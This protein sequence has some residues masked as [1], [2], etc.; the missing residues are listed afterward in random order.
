MFFCA[1]V[2]FLPKLREI[3]G[4]GVLPIMAYAGRLL[5]KGVTFFTL[6]VYERVGNSRVEVYE[7]EGKSVI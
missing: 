6:Q 3:P 5:P 4:E 1:F 2:D 7:S